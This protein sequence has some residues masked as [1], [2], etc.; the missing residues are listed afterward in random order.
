MT[1]FE[2][3]ELGR[4]HARGDVAPARSRVEQVVVAAG[5]GSPAL[6]ELLGLPR[7][8][9]VAGR[10]AGDV[11]LLVPAGGRDRRRPERVRDRRRQRCR[12]CCTWTATRRCTP[13]T[14]RSSPTSSGAST[15]SR[16]STSVQGGAAPLPQGHEF[17]VDPYPTGSVEPGFPDLW[18]AAL[19][20]CMERFEGS[21]PLYRQVRSGG[22]GAF[23]ADNFPV[24][25]YMRPNV[26]VAADSNHG[27]KMIAV[28]REIARV[29]RGRRA[30]GPAAPVPLRA[31]RDRGPAPGVEQPVSLVLVGG[32]RRARSQPSTRP[33][34]WI[35][36]KVVPHLPGSVSST[37]ASRRSEASSSSLSL[38]SRRD[39]SATLN[40]SGKRR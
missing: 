19:S 7:R 31:L 27:Y 17:E 40:W 32:A 16:T 37:S 30:L 38:S 5:P 6:W 1:G 21:R 20:H 22:V 24:F 14:A 9:E 36:V 13:T 10:R 35:R 25:D 2:L 3:D 29:L 8:L 15:S 11:D 12:R 28:G 33:Q 34:L 23:T 4:R 39:S 26:F 18:C